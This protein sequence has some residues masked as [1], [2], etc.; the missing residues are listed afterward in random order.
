MYCCLV[1]L[2]RLISF[3]LWSGT[4]FPEYPNCIHKLPCLLT[5][6][7]WNLF[8]LI[9]FH[10]LRNFSAQY[11]LK[12]SLYPCTQASAVG[13]P[14]RGLRSSCQTPSPAVLHHSA[15]SRER[16]DNSGKCP[17]GN[18]SHQRG[19]GQ[20]GWA[21][22]RNSRKAVFKPGHTLCPCFTIREWIQ[23]QGSYVMFSASTPSLSCLPIISRQT[24]PSTG[25]IVKKWVMTV[26]KSIFN[27]QIQP[28]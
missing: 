14:K 15:Q 8:F 13:A 11:L 12:N 28:S 10:P 19:W 2:S 21:G 3:D 27:P 26:L 7:T 22:N 9:S 24:L 4:I 18:L 20:E 6:N 25:Q 5:V 17:W 16:P 23:H 1:I